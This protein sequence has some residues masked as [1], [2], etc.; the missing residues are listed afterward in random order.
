MASPL[1]RVSG[2]FIFIA[3]SWDFDGFNGLYTFDLS[4]SGSN[5]SARNRGAVAIYKLPGKWIVKRHCFQDY[6]NVLY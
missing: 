5:N 2:S 6:K 1:F 3:T 4:I